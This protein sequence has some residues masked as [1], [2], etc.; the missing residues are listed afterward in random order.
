MIALA[1]HRKG[2]IKN[3]G[4]RTD[5]TTSKKW[6]TGIKNDMARAH[7]YFQ[8]SSINHPCR[9]YSENAITPTISEG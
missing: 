8:T 4:F 6:A 9:C 2:Q 1:R 5:F 7:I 3:Y